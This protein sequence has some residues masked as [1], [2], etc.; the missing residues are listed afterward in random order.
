MA[1]YTLILKKVVLILRQSGLDFLLK[2][3]F[4]Y[5][6]FYLIKMRM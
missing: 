3:D 2:W 5:F 1:C 4:K 6:I